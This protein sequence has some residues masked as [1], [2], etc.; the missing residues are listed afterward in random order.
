[1][2][3]RFTLIAKAGGS[4]E[5]AENTCEAIEAARA[6][7]PPA[8]ARLAF[9]VDVR[10]TADDVPIAMHDASLERTTGVAWRVRDV[11][12]RRVK[13]LRAGPRGERVPILDAVLDAVGEHEVVLEAHDG[14]ERMARALV[15]TLDRRSRV[16]QARVIVASEHG[17]LIRRVR[18]LR[19]GVRTAA[20]PREAWQKL[21]VDRLGLPRLAPRGVTWMVPRTHRG[22]DV[23]TPRFARSAAAAGDDLW[24]YVIDDA[25][26]ALALRATGVS[27][28]FTTKPVA[29]AAALA[30]R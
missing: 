14:D 25:R 17:A 23:V 1:M 16:E 29:L 18:G 7:A 8:W 3:S 20:T 2:S 28:C 4:G 9:E 22:L 27:G 10:L 24:V 12:I 19:P 21:L 30:H 6:A 5:G 13:E 26:E 15:R 11:G